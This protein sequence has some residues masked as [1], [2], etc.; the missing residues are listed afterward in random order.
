[1]RKALSIISSIVIIFVMVIMILIAGI[2]HVG[3]KPYSYE[4]GSAV[5]VKSVAE[6]DISDKIK[7]GDKI[8]YILNENNLIATSVVHHI[9]FDNKYFYVLPDDLYK[10]ENNE[11]MEEFVPV[12]FSGFKG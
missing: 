6:S 2:E 12:Q 1:M 11:N 3:I 5:Y 10:G 8:T 9:D 4:N 7:I